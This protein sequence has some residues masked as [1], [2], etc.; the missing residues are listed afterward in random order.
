MYHDETASVKEC[1]TLT[2]AIRHGTDQNDRPC[3]ERRSDNW[4]IK[5]RPMKGASE[6]DDEEGADDFVCVLPSRF[7]AL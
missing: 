3:P 4:L 7:P 5:P 6:D 2:A 1:R